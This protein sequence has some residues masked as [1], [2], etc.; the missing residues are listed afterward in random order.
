M[1]CYKHLN[2]EHFKSLMSVQ[3]TSRVG[4]KSWT[5]SIITGE[6][7]IYQRRFFY[8]NKLQN[9]DTIFF[10]LFAAKKFWKLSVPY[11]NTIWPI[12]VAGEADK[13]LM[14]LASACH[15]GRPNSVSQRYSLASHKKTLPFKY[16]N[17]LRKNSHPAENWKRDVSISR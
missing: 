7:G 12:A 17:N 9:N 8:R 6:G 10:C 2:T 1:I 15:L 5:I 16:S 3:F 4:I 13:E 14:L 11:A